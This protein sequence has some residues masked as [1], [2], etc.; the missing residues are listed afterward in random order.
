MRLESMKSMTKATKREVMSKA[1]IN[2]VDRLCLSKSQLS[3]VL[4][5]STTKVTRLYIHTY[6]LSPPQERMGLQ[7]LA[8]K[9]FQIS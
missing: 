4:G 8:G 7:C 9:A 2:A 3:K 5:L 1:V 6:E